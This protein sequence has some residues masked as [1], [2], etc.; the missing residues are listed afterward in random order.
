MNKKTFYVVQAY[1][2]GKRG[3]IS[4]GTP[5]EARTS[6]DAT[7]IAKRLSIIRL[8]AVAFSRD[9]GSDEKSLGKPIIIASFGR[10]PEAVNVKDELR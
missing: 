7:R 1:E 4:V 9:T 5:I 6:E 2:T 10:V 3:V 8:G